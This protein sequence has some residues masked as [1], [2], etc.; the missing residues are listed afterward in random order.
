MKRHSVKKK[1][2]L[3]AWFYNM[4]MYHRYVQCLQRPQ[5]GSDSLELELWAAPSHHMGLEQPVVLTAE[6]S[7]RPSGCG[8]DLPFPDDNRRSASFL[9][10]HCRAP[11]LEKCR[12][13]SLALYLFI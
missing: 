10:H 13:K 12:F 6:P 7:L 2:L 5:E 3:C 11:A 8:F 1:N 9:V 4:Y